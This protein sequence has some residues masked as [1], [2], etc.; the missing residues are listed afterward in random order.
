MNMTTRFLLASCRFL[1]LKLAK[2]FLDSFFH[3][4]HRSHNSCWQPAT[5]WRLPHPLIHLTQLLL[6]IPD[7]EDNRNQSGTIKVCR[8]GFKL[9]LNGVWALAPG[10]RVTTWF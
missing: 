6:C 4:C 2:D 9:K 7:Y 3:W 5:S 8:D 1:E 10:A